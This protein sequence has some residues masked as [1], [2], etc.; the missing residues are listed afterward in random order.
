M[1]SPPDPSRAA[2]AGGWATRLHEAADEVVWA[3]KLN[4]LWLVFTLT[5]GIF[6]GAPHPNAAKLY[7]TWF[8]AKEQQSRVGSFSSRADVAPPEGFAPLTSYK[9][10]NNYREFMTDEKLITELRQRMGAA[11]RRRAVAEYS[12]ERLVAPLCALA[13]GD[14]TVLRAAR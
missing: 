10:A 9:I 8:L 11:A 4:L 6:K 14:L 2:T 13:Q 7:L 1:L 12:Y 3:A 5:G